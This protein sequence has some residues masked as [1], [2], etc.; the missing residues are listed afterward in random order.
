VSRCEWTRYKREK[1]ATGDE[2]EDDIT[3]DKSEINPQKCRN[4]AELHPKAA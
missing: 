1:R 2:R 3:K 4:T